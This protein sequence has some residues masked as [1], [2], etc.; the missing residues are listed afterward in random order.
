MAVVRLVQRKL[1]TRCI[2]ISSAFGFLKSACG[3]TARDQVVGA[4]VHQCTSRICEANRMSLYLTNLSTQIHH[5]TQP[6]HDAVNPVAAFIHG[7]H[8]NEMCVV[9]VYV[10]VYKGFMDDTQDL[11]VWPQFIFMT[12]LTDGKR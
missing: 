4:Y 12:H 5:S 3:T 10:F 2:I 9:Y 11:I 7:L 8:R 6:S 1:S